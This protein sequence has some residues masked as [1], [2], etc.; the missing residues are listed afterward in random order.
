MDLEQKKREASR[1]TI[2]RAVNAGRPVGVG[3]SII[4]SV[5]KDAGNPTARDAI[6]RELTYLA[7]AGLLVLFRDAEEWQA[8]PTPAGVDV[9]EYVIPAPAGIARPERR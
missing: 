4:A 1:W 8:R 5:L 9:V 7:D 3:E 6:R 2:L